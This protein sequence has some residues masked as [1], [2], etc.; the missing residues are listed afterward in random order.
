MNESTAT[1]INATILTATLTSFLALLVDLD[2]LADLVSIGTLFV[3]LMVSLACLWKRYQ[4]RDQPVR[5]SLTA[6]TASLLISSA[7]LSFNYTCNGHEAMS[8]VALAL[9]VASIAAL[10]YEPVAFRATRFRIPLQPIVP[11]LAV[12]TNIFLIS[13]LGA[14]AYVGF[15][16]LF[17]ASLIWYLAYGVHN[18][19][20]P[21]S[22]SPAPSVSHSL[23]ATGTIDSINID[24][25]EADDLT[26]K[27]LA[28]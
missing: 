15:L 27:L 17:V 5:M 11:C 21:H 14:T 13:S 6:K 26:A 3:F 28:E 22:F 20:E 10:C 9:L 25:L 23:H 18:S 1:P 2:I 7:V 16:A 24:D 8:Y 19:F 4:T 12:F